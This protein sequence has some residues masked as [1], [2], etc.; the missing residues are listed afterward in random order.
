MKRT[1]TMILITGATGHVGSELITALLPSQAGHIRALT[2][3]P[4]AVFPNGTERVVAD[5]GD[6][7]LTPALESYNRMLW[8]ALRR[9]AAYLPG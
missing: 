7:D 6:S 5:L 4:D 8:T 3:N 2:R 9:K 1:K